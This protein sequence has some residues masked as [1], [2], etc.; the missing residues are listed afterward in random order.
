MN[1]MTRVEAL[2][3]ERRLT[4]RLTRLPRWQRAAALVA[5]LALATAIGAELLD[6]PPPAAAAQMV[7]TVTV[8][9]P[10]RA[11]VVEWDEHVG[12]F[13][14]SRAVDVRPRVSG[15]L[16]AIHF[17]DGDTV[18]QGQLLFTIDPRPF[19]AAL[20]E[21]RARQADAQAKLA[22]ARSDL[23]RAER[24]IDD[25]AV[26]REE[27]DALRAAARSAEAMLA[28]ARAQVEA[29]ALEVE[30]TRVRAPITGRISDRRVDVGNLVGGQAEAATLLTT[31]HAV[32]PIY[33][34]FEASEALHLKFLRQGG[35]AQTA[36][37]RL[38]DEP[39]YR[40]K[41]GIDFTDNEVNAA[42]GTVRGRVVMANPTG[43]LTPGMFGNMRLAAGGAR[44]A[45]LVPDAAVQTDQARKVVLVVGADGT[46]AAKPV[47]PG[48][49]VGDYRVVRCGLEATDRVV[50]AGMQFATPGGKVR[51]QPTRLALNQAQGRT[52][53]YTAP[54][55]SQATLAE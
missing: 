10:V 26:S 42:A 19:E 30:F 20:A 24:L 46:V 51:T 11:N 38:Q 44:S 34:T 27:V 3:A 52:P 31:I 45:L 1:M 12:R 17:R 18:R 28:A 9:A 55:A 13:E 2:R 41:G 7:P 14:A 36:E 4:A 40:W 53:A 16:Q 5:P 47:E 21:A 25:E 6:S 54:P 43:F 29:R 33:F 35:G 23:A 37:V 48:A 50:V 8:A 22:L 15:A 39:D 49:R 32:D